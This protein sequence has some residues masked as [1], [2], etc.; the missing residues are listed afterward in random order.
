ME[1]VFL[2]AFSHARMEGLA[3]GIWLEEAE[4][5]DEVG[6]VLRASRSSAGGA[7]RGGGGCGDGE[8]CSLTTL[9]VTGSS[10]FP[11]ESRAS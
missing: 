9:D 6:E 10:G 7:G 1:E 4:M 3:P 11:F 5:T 8:V 2:L